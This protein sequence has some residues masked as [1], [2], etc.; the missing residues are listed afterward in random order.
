MKKSKILIAL[1]L[2]V[3]SASAIQ[4]K[5]VSRTKTGCFPGC[6]STSRTQELTTYVDCETG[7]TKQYWAVTI[8][9]SGT[10]LKS[11]PNA[12]AI[13]PATNDGVFENT[14][15]DGMLTHAY[16]EIGNGNTNGTYTATYINTTSNETWVYSVNW[17][18]TTNADGTLTE[19]I[20]VFKEKICTN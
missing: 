19:Q 12:S 2:V 9:C 15:A 18:T 8:G 11:C 20:D 7:E 10:G 3:F 16:V 17:I 14:C 4:T 13:P 5:V 1:I 6:G